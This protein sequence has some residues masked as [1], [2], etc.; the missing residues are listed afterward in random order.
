MLTSNGGTSSIKFAPPRTLLSGKVSLG[1]EVDAEAPGASNPTRHCEW[2]DGQGSLSIVG[3]RMA[4]ITEAIPLNGSFFNA[5]RMVTQDL[6]N[7]C[8]P[9]DR[10]GERG[11]PLGNQGQMS[12]TGKILIRCP[13]MSILATM[14]PWVRECQ[15]LVCPNN[16]IVL[17]DGT[18]ISFVITFPK[19]LVR[20]QSWGN[21][22]VDKVPAKGVTRDG[23]TVCVTMEKERVTRTSLR[24]MDASL[25]T[26]SERSNC[27]GRFGRLARVFH[28][29]E[30]SR[31][32]PN[33]RPRRP[34]LDFSS[35]SPRRLRR[36]ASWNSIES[37]AGGFKRVSVFCEAANV[38]GRS[39]MELARLIELLSDVAAYP[40]TG[41]KVD[42][43]Q[44][45]ISVVF[46][47]GPYAFKIK[48]PVDLGFLDFSTLEKRRH[49]CEEEVRLNRRLAPEIYLGVVPITRM[50]QGVRIED[51]GE[52]IEWAVKMKRLSDEATLQSRLQHQNVTSETVEALAE[53]I[54]SF[55]AEAEASDRISAFGR[56]EVVSGNAR[57]NFEQS[58]PQIGTTLSRAVFE[59]LQV[60]TE[61]ALIRHQHLIEGR[62]DRGVPRDTHGDLRLG[63][64]Y[65]F[66]ERQ[67]PANLAIIDCIEFNERF[68]FADPVADMAFLAMGLAFH[69]R[70]DLARAFTEA[71]FRASGDDEGRTLLPFYTAYRAAVRGKV[72]GFKLSR[73][74]IPSRE[75]T[76]ALAKA[77]AYWLFALGELEDPGQRPCLILVGGL[78]GTGKSTLAR[79]LARQATFSV[80]RSD[81]VRKELAGATGG[82]DARDGD[83]NSEAFEQGIYTPDWTNR[84]YAEC[85]HRAED[86]LFQGKRVL[87]DANFR[88]EKKRQAFF[89][90]AARL[91]VPAVFLLCEAGPDVVQARLRSR[92]N[93]ASDA[94]WSIFLKAAACWEEP[95]PSTLGVLRVVSTVASEELVVSKA[96]KSLQEFGL[97][98]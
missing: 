95:S 32:S 53:R 13:E 22:L 50:G 52:V 10:S 8:L 92:Q 23:G 98:D 40:T 77:R 64:V 26:L 17:D 94:D 12:M 34:A 3:K 4:E 56:F 35:M 83:G 90:L 43:C 69:G 74:E 49:F 68:R 20:W 41:K 44:T 84:T 51:Q 71:Y 27:S 67:P 76:L 58:A 11:R 89:E 86:L 28:Q 57:E 75:Q 88:E 80:I 38:R 48:K 55:H 61:A 5:Q 62:A 1:F 16:E 42:I 63:H 85:L 73:K 2:H 7:A 72:E 36:E 87:I 81:L 39:S 18:K 15:E 31:S 97:C 82:A 37:V 29:Q 65:L 93:D 91:G 96:L 46:L 60:L 33:A 78:P 45:H 54:A 6:Q 70:R 59:R 79:A 24:T 47:A 21:W 9:A 19:A 14:K 66:P 25:A 30:K